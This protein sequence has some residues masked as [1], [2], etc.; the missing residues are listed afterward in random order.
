[1]VST[2]CPS[3]RDAKLEPMIRVLFRG[4]VLPTAEPRGFTFFV[5]LGAEVRAFGFTVAGF[6]VAVFAFAL[7]A[8]AKTLREPVEEALFECLRIAIFLR[9]LFFLVFFLVAMPQ[10]YHCGPARYISRL[11]DAIASKIASSV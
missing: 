3:P 2:L 11:S 1:M 8:L 10:V 4:A 6:T 9:E 7:F 5:T